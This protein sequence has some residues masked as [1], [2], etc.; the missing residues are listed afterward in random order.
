MCVLCL[1][2][3]TQVPASKGFGASGAVLRPTEH[4]PEKSGVI[5]P[6]AELEYDIELI[7]VSIPPS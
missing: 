2:C 7:R 3:A 1:D 4:V 5:P 6:D